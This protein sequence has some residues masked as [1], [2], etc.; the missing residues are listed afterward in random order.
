MQRPSTDFLREQCLIIWFPLTGN[1]D[2]V[3]I[4]RN[5]SSIKKY[6]KLSVKIKEQF[7]Y[8]IQGVSK[9]RYF[10]DFHLIY[11][12]EIGFYFFTCV[13]ESKFRTQSI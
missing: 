13:S 11:V 2:G 1:L 6:A 3:F 7:M 5:E 9:K 8:D 12:L 10:F 4:I